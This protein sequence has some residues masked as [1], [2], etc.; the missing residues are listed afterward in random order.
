MTALAVTLKPGAQTTIQ[1]GGRNNYRHLGVPLSGAADR[2]SLAFANTALGNPIGAGALECSL[3]GPVL[4]FETA[5]FFCL[6][7]ADMDATF[8]GAPVA[9]YKAVKAQPNDILALSAARSGARA[10]FAVKGGLSGDMF[11]GSAATYLPAKLG[12][13]DGRALQKG[14]RLFRAAAPTGNPA[15]IPTALRFHPGHDYILRA[16]A[17]PDAEMISPKTVETFF[18]T[19][20]SADN[21]ANRMGVRLTGDEFIQIGQAQMKSSAVFLGTVQCPPDGAPFLLLAD[22][23]TTGGY[24][25]I[26]QVIA[27]DLPLAG[28]IRPGDRVWFRKVDEAQARDITAKKEALIKTAAPDF[29]FY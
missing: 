7:G 17:G 22:A 26:A 9:L 2:L 14:D 1:D 10:Y 25:R 27:A 18:G 3:N 20:F 21:R 4:K 13:L 15:T 24:L 19:G 5:T 6:T 29:S 16:T 11:L 8:N 23:Q 12:G 28:Q